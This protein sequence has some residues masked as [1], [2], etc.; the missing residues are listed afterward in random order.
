M[1]AQDTM[2]VT[3]S[4]VIHRPI[5]EVRT[6]FADIPY[7]VRANVHP[8]LALTVLATDG[9]RCSFRQEVRI[10]GMKQVDEVV[11]TVLED[12]NMRSEVVG[13]TNQGLTIHFSYAPAAQDATR[14][15]A[16][17]QIPKHGVKRLLAPLFAFGVRRA[18]TKA[19]EQDRRDLESGR[20]RAYCEARR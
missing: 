14:V 16:R 7:H 6:Q 19:L 5:E 13:G 4:D 18:A 3:V 1:A 9:R 15:T 11:N 20:C 10:A 17:F 2:V 8:E 12:G